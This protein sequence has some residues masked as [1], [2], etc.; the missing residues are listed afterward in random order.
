MIKYLIVIL[1]ISI[2]CNQST[3]PQ[4]RRADTTVIADKLGALS[5]ALAFTRSQIN[6][7]DAR[8]KITYDSI[9]A[10]NKTI[11]ELKGQIVVQASMITS[12]KAIAS[13]AAVEA[14]K[15]DKISSVV[16]SGHWI[17][18]PDGSFGFELDTAVTNSIFRQASAINSQSLRLQ[19]VE[20][21][22]RGPLTFNNK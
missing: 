11:A 15:R 16:G 21:I 22:V 1:L 9:A 3:T 17:K 5:S 13:N 12:V 7:L 4:Q 6:Y 19:R 20:Q 8:F 2:R 18:K 10:L 14:V